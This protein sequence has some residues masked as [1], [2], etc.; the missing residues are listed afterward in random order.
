MDCRQ[1]DGTVISDLLLKFKG[2]LFTN[3]CYKKIVQVLGSQKR[4]IEFL[5]YFN[6]VSYKHL[7]N[8]V[9]GTINCYSFSYTIVVFR[10]S[11]KRQ[12]SVWY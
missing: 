11:E 9:E 2:V 1:K 12:T 4:K 6:N 8:F 5:K 7:Q 10:T 3:T